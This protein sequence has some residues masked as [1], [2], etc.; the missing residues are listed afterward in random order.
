[1]GFDQAW[2]FRFL[3]F[4][5]SKANAFTHYVIAHSTWNK[6]CCSLC[7]NNG[8]MVSTVVVGGLIWHTS[9]NIKQVALF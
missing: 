1:M 2:I 9:S 7:S 6:N 8:R 4:A 5:H 3:L